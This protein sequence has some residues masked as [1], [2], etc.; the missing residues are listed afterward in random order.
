MLRTFNCGIGMIAL[1]EAAR[2]DAVMASLRTAGET[3][4]IFGEVVPL[5][6]GAPPVV[7]TGNLDLAW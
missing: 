4:M 3:A 7:Y 6:S 5:A 1:V 2:V